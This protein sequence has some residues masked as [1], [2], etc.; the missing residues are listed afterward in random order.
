MYSIYNSG[1]LNRA[2]EALNSIDFLEKG[3][4]IFGKDFNIRVGN[5]KEG[6]TVIDDRNSIERC[7]KDTVVSKNSLKLIKLAENKAWFVL[8]AACIRNEKKEYTY[9]GS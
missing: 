8:N 2:S 7:S 6:G 9:T 3:K 1:D 5:L 4:L